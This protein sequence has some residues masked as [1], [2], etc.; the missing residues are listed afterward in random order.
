MSSTIAAI[1]TATAAAG[2]A[3]IRL[4]GTDALPIADAVFRP[5]DPKKCLSSLAGYSA[6]YGHVYDREGDIDECVALVFR[7]PH[8]YTGEDVVEISCHGGLYLTRRVLQALLSAGAVPA[9]PGEFTRRAFTNG[10]IDLTQAEA[11]M[12]LIAADG[13][14]AARSALAVRE[15]S[16]H[17]YLEDVRQR[18]T[19][20]AA[21]L[22][23]YVD[24]P[25]DDIPDLSAHELEDLLIQAESRLQ[26]LLSTYEAG[27][28][29]REGIDTVIAGS[30]NVGKST[31][32]NL[33]AG[34]ERSI[35]TSVA[36]TTRDIVE[37]CVRLGDVTLRLSDTAGIRQGDSE[38][39]QIGIDRARRRARS[40]ALLLCVFDGSR[41]L[42]ESDREI[43]ALA[44]GQAAIALI[45]KSDNPQKIDESYI[46]Q[47]FQQ[48]IHISALMGEGREALIQAV[49]RLADI[50]RLEGAEAVLSTERQRAGAE[51]CLNSVKEALTALR[52]HITL[53]AVGVCID[54]ALSALLE[55][56]GEKATES[57][58]EEIFSRFCVG[59]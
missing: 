37:E 56:S 59:K 54:D 49:G 21:S 8:S 12:D 13:R 5:A 53:D 27:R 14:L 57:V 1:S 46:I 44:D 30:P 10:K 55:L 50:K 52:G 58:V 33:L 31:L 9:G 51:R 11:V 39:E 43:A 38:A 3:V 36:G 26:T 42:E 15:G 47:H 6:L 2:L 17:R 34:C 20:A 23:A 16:V 35:V 7:S 19:G 4:S 41:P 25:D 18:L 32:M 48:V 28:V 24:Y 22:L 45:N 40:A 29:I